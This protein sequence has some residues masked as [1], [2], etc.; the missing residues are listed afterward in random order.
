MTIGYD[1]NTN[2]NINNEEWSDLCE[3]VLV[4]RQQESSSSSSV[5]L[6]SLP[7]KD[8]LGLGQET[9]DDGGG[10]FVLHLHQP[11]NC[12][13]STLLQ[14]PVRSVDNRPII[15]GFGGGRNNNDES[16]SKHNHN[17]QVHIHPLLYEFLF[18]SSN[19]VDTGDTDIIQQQESGTSVQIQPLPMEPPIQRFHYEGRS[20]ILTPCCADFRMQSVKVTN[21]VVDNESSSQY[22]QSIRILAT[23]IFVDVDDFDN[24]TNTQLMFAEALEGRIVMVG[25]I[26]LVWIWNTT[27]KTGSSSSSSAQ[28]AIL[29]IDDIFFV[30]QNSNDNIKDDTKVTTNSS[31]RTATA[32]RLGSIDTFQVQIKI[33]NIDDESSETTTGHTDDYD[34]DG[35]KN[36]VMMPRSQ[37][38]IDSTTVPGYQTLLN[39]I[40]QSLDDERIPVEATPSGILL[41]GCAGVGKSRL[42]NCV[43][44]HYRSTANNRIKDT[45]DDTVYNLSVHNLFFQ[46]AT[47]NDLLQDIILPGLTKHGDN[48]CKLWII[49]DLTML[50]EE[51]QD[52]SDKNRSSEYTCVLN[53]ILR[54]IDMFHSKIAIIGIG[55]TIQNLPNELIKVGRLETQIEMT[56]PTQWQRQEIWESI[57][58]SLE[59]DND[60]NAA[61]TKRRNQWTTTLV[62]TTAGCVAADLIRIYETATTKALARGSLLPTTTV[63]ID[64]SSEE[65]REFS[66]LLQWEDLREAARFC[67]PS[68]L[69]DLD[70]IKPGTTFDPSTTSWAEMHQQS[71]AVFGGYG[72]IKKQIYRNVVAPWHN[73]LRRMNTA[74]TE[75]SKEGNFNWLTPPT[76]VIFHGPSGCGKSFAARCLASSLQLPMVQIRATDVLNKYLG[77]SEALLRSFFARARASSPCILFLD[78]IDAISNNRV[79]DDTNELGARILSTLLNEMD[80][81][82]TTKNNQV[83]VIACSNRLEAIDSALLRSGRLEEHLYLGPPTSDD[84]LGILKLHTSRMPLDE[85]LSLDTVASRLCELNSTPAEVEGLCREACFHCFRRLGNDLDDAVTLLPEDFDKAIEARSH[86]H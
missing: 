66:D 18:E 82:A 58:L 49:D 75:S 55:R 31:P 83:L 47:T 30:V 26:I 13:A 1:Y 70:V 60:Q 11:G 32:Y 73:F 69:A 15:S 14:R 5:S 53:A 27:T 51:S 61:A 68:Q 48:Y 45:D 79:E 50:E 38:N 85:R 34:E 12:L 17:I 54:G 57:L 76:G 29:R 24:D 41:T 59:N 56:S 72:A 80:G 9:S 81:V 33:N 23:C 52:D 7:I 86:L 37:K 8:I 19:L 21:V 40:L 42:V 67:V 10:D 63:T 4:R 39:N 3:V 20:N 78:E 2:N 6:P 71:W 25:S 36:G 35:E 28:P 74:S 64:S 62:A 46:A 22:N 44:N 84:L 65:E 16:G 77:G 43:A